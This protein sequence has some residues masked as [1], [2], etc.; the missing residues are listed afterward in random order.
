MKSDKNF[1]Y[2]GGSWR[3]DLNENAAVWFKKEEYEKNSRR[4]EEN[5]TVWQARNARESQTTQVW[6]PYFNNNRGDTV[7]T[8]VE[9]YYTWSFHLS[10]LRVRS[11]FA[12]VHIKH[13]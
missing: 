1:N 9:M 12:H 5:E 10:F 13:L 6:N 11:Y 3:L 4:S 7:P 8:W 2:N